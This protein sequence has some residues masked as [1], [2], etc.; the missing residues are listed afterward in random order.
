VS[1]LAPR[2]TA[3]PEE[4]AV[5]TAAYF[6]LQRRTEAEVV[7]DTTPLWRFSRRWFQPPR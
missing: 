7:V 3:T 2:T 4:I 6:A 1:N 5:V